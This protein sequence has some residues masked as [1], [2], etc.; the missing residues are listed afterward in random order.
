MRVKGLILLGVMIAVSLIYFLADNFGGCTV[1]KV[2]EK[3]SRESKS[4]AGEKK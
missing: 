1:V 2:N 4:E 3:P